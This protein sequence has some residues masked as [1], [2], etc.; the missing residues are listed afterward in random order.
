M[1]DDA[2]TKDVL[3]RIAG[4]LER[5]AP[6]AAVPTDWLAYPA[7]VW[8]GR[9]ARGIAALDAPRLELLR[10]IDA[11]KERVTENVARLAQGHSAHDM[12]L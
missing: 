12:L 3:A 5:L 9:E 7:Y 6:P 11:Q 1:P 8:T 10:G 2:D 4:A